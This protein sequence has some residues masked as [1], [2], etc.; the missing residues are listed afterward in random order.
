M[1]ELNSVF[2]SLVGA[3]WNKVLGAYTVNC[4]SRFL[5]C[6]PAASRPASPVVFPPVD[7]LVLQSFHQ[8]TSQSSSLSTSRPASRVVFPP[9][10][11]L[12]LQSFHQQTSQSCSLSTGRP[13]SPV[14]F[15]PVDQQVVQSF[16]R[17]T[18]QVQQSLTKL[19]QG[20]PMSIL[21]VYF[22]LR[23]GDLKTTGRKE[24]AL[25]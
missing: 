16:H 11:Q 4:R 20:S 9:V 2:V 21:Q 5:S 15:P 14:V 19:Q 24:D 8:Q 3:E 13:A 25:L 23:S 1:D 22:F 6:T 7:Q 17:Q 10:D 12:V 18:S